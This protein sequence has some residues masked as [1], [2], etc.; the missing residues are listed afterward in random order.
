MS[1]EIVVQ[2]EKPAR[3][4]QLLEQ[5]EFVDLIKE[6]CCKGASDLEFRV[7]L[8]HCKALRLNPLL[9][10]VWALPFW[11]SDAEKYKYS[12]VIGIDGFRKKAQETGLY[13][14]RLGPEWCG[15]DGRWFDVWLSDELPAAARVHVIRKDC[16]KPITGTAKFASFCRK[17]KYGKLISKWA[18]MPEHMIAKCAEA[19]ALRAAFPDSFSNVYSAEELDHLPRSQAEVIDVSNS[20]ELPPAQIWEPTKENIIK[21]KDDIEKHGIDF[22][23]DNKPVFTEA[24]ISLTGVLLSEYEKKLGEYIEDILNVSGPLD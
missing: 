24:K 17:N 6:Q 5:K 14:G 3:L 12:T 16:Q 8:E 22:N 11:D 18:T 19:Q 13:G 21:L 15:K 9:K 4:L 23:D 7:F 10:Q 2:E 20:V 1:N